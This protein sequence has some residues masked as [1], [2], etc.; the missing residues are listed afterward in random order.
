MFD[1]ILLLQRLTKVE[2]Q[3]Q[4]IVLDLLFSSLV[5]CIN[6]YD[7]LAHFHDCKEL[8]HA[9]SSSVDEGK[10]HFQRLDL[11]GGLGADVRQEQMAL[12][13]TYWRTYS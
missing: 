6:N 13:H 8:D 10:G 11:P 1:Y 12:V 9:G 4:D 5:F 3:L 7:H 2:L